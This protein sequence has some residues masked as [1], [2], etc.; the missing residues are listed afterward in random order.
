MEDKTVQTDNNYY[1]Y[2]NRIVRFFTRTD[3]GY[4]FASIDNQ[5][6]ISAFNSQLIQLLSE[7]QL[8]LQ[9][10]NFNDQS[11]LPLVEQLQKPTKLDVKT[12]IVN[13]L[14]ILAELRDGILTEKGS[15][16]IQKFNFA[17]EA[18]NNLDV[19]ILSGQAEVY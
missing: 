14:R 7:K 8:N 3:S 16:S 2:L 12:L 19:P 5:R 13:N 10:F 9:I 15:N 18:L 17:R 11:G 6:H 4:A 1:A